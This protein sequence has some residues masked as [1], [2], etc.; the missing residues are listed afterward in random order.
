[1]TVDSIRL[2]FPTL[3]Q[4]VYG[5]PLVYLD[6]GATTQKPLQVIDA[7]E[8]YYMH[9]N[10]NVH[11]GVH[12]LSQ[13]ADKAY[14]GSREKVRAFINAAS[15]KEVIFTKG[16]TDS[17]NLLAASF[18]DAFI[19]AG[20]E[21]IITGMEHHANIVPW[22]QLC[23]RKRAV[24]RVIP[25]LDNGELCME[26]YRSL[27]SSKTKL[28]SVVHVSNTLGTV[29]PI[30]DIIADAHARD[31][32]VMLDVAQSIQHMPFDV[33]KLD[34]DFLAF[35]G[36]KIY[37]PTGVG[38]LY[39]KQQWLDAMPPYQTGGDM[40]REVSFEGTTF[41]E[42][43]FKFEA[44]TPNIAGVIGLGAA[45]DF[46][47][48]IGWDVIESHEAMLAEY[49]V[50]RLSGVPGLQIIGSPKHRIAT[51]SFVMD[52]IHPHDL[53][54]ILDRQGVAIRAGHHCT[55]P[56]IKRFGV[57]ATARASL[58]LYNTQA[59]VDALT[60]ALLT[61]VEVFQV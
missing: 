18:G 10:A 43:P 53:A 2:Q 11:R 45:I 47:K 14:E 12:A 35:S 15:T 49:L 5:K 38:V 3:N 21:I 20:D 61:A 50:E 56:L 52:G 27:L 13:R 8:Q 1:M 34:C 44:G 6:N 42:L 22:Q 40:I 33:Q 46:V 41:N 37:G 59:E 51:V 54:T 32:P 36:H 31:I 16:T 4:S 25:V 48:Q 23:Q 26:T 39:G 58:A 24:L 57:P 30:K 28:V 29:N 60:E 55:M 9:D 17:I 7:L 19:H